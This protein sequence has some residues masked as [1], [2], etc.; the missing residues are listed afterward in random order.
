MSP[1]YCLDRNEPGE[2]PI[3]AGLAPPAGHPLIP[4]SR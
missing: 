3:A 2:L 4:G 1:R